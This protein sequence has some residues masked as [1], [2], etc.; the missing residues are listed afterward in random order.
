MSSIKRKQQ[1]K[2][3][4][5]GKKLELKKETLRDL[6]AGKKG[7]AVRGGAAHGTS[8]GCKL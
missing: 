2:S 6:T 7:R 8:G 1:G 3:G 5:K 4:A